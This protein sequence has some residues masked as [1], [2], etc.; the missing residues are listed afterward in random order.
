MKE[1]LTERFKQHLMREGDGDPF[2]LLGMH[3]TDDGKGVYVRVCYPGADKIFVLSADGKKELAVMDKV[4]PYGLFQASF[5]NSSFF[6]YKLRIC[7]LGGRYYEALDPYSFGPILSDF[8][9]Y[10]L[11]QGTHKNLYDILGAHLVEHEGVKGVR[12][13]VWAP[14]ARRV[15]VVGNFNTWDGR[16]HMMRNRTNTGVWELYIPDLVEGEYYKYEIVD[17]KG[18]VQPLKADPIAFHAELRPNT[19]SIVYD[20]KRYKWSDLSWMKQRKLQKDVLHRPMSIYEVHLGSWRRNSLEKNRFL[21]QEKC[22]EM[23]REFL[24]I[25]KHS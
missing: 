4:H 20:P 10:L 15:S 12:F 2:G 6:K 18:Q 9:L 5:P 8:D 21:T 11:G 14:N 22:R 17:N 25:Q 3:E 16:R 1:K 19:A 24:R 7:F 13:A 23:G